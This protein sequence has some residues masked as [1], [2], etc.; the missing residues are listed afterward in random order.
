[1]ERKEKSFLSG[2]TYE[3]VRSNIQL[4]DGIPDP[5]VDGKFIVP[6]DPEDQEFL[7]EYYSDLGYDVDDFTTEREWWTFLET[8]N[9]FGHTYGGREDYYNNVLYRHIYNGRVIGNPLFLTRPT[10]TRWAN[11]SEGPYVINNRILGHQFGFKGWLF[12]ALQYRLLFT[13]TRNR[14]AWQEYGGRF[15]WEGIKTDPDFEWYWKGD[16]DQYYTLLELGYEPE[17]WKHFR[18]ILG[19]GYDFGDIYSNF[20]GMV[21]VRYNFY[22][23]LK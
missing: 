6:S 23:L 10:L 18:F 4:G 1:M 8:Y 19:M 16:R 17:K 12:K 9:N 13:F 11:N 14:G 22:P 5:R 2:F 7:R 3:W 21:S 15:Q 20:G